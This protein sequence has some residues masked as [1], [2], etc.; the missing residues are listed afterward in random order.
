MVRGGLYAVHIIL[1]ATGVVFHSRA[2]F[3]GLHVNGLRN[4]FLQSF[5]Q[6]AVHALG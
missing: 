3:S 2:A 1:A 6:A 5:Q 4:G